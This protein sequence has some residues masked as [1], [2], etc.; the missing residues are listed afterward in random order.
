MQWKLQ[1]DFC[2]SFFFFTFSY[3]WWSSYIWT[4]NDLFKFSPNFRIFLNLKL[5]KFKLADNLLQ[6][7]HFLQICSPE[8]SVIVM[9]FSDST[10][11]SFRVLKHQFLEKEVKCNINSVESNKTLWFQNFFSFCG[12]CWYYRHSFLPLLKL[13]GVCFWNLDKEGGHEKIA[14]K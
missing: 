8:L 14:L 12:K 1:C 4:S 13:G 10:V 7:C 3:I 6:I 2:L 5:L 11:L 9:L